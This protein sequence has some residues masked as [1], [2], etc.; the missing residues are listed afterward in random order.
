VNSDI[1][2]RL[3][4]HLD[5]LEYEEK[6][7]N[8]TYLNKDDIILI[9]DTLRKNDMELSPILDTFQDMVSIFYEKD[10]Y[11]MKNCI[12]ELL[13][14]YNIVEH[15]NIM[16]TR[17]KFFFSE[18]RNLVKKPFFDEKTIQKIRDILNVHKIFQKL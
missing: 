14:Y 18:S 3:D 11:Y 2:S 16:R 8:G 13:K 17:H 12:C 9:F 5:R 4:N 10:H 1:T 7:Q 6:L 15:K